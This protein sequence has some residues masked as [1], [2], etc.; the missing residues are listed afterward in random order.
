[1]FK[2]K[3]FLKEYFLTPFRKIINFFKRYILYSFFSFKY[4]IIKSKIKNKKKVLVAF[5]LFNTDT[6]KADTVFN[7][8]KKSE[9]FVPY[10]VICPLVGKGNSFMKNQYA[11]CLDFV[12]KNN[13]RYL[14]GFEI[15]KNDKLIKKKIPKFD[16][17]FFL[18]P[19][20]ITLKSFTV[21][22]NKNSLN[23]Y[24]PYSFNIDNLT[25]Y[26]YNN[27]NI[28]LMYKVFTLSEYHYN[29][30]KKYSDLKAKNCFV[31]GFPQL[32]SFF[33]KPKTNPWIYKNKSRKKIIWGPHWT[34][35][36]KQK[37]GLDWSC[38]LD[39]SDEIL[40]LAN[41]YENEV[42]FTLKPHPFLFQLL[43]KEDNWGEQKTNQYIAKWDETKNCQ[44][45]WGNY[46]DL[47]IHSDAL[48]HD[49]GSFTI[50]YLCTNK[51]VAYTI[52]SENY[53]NRFNDIGKK[54]IDLHHIIKDKF[55][56]EKF[57][58]EVIEEKDNM[59]KLRENFRNNVLLADG[60]SGERIVSHLNYIVK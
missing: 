10:I 33:S 52:N 51:P 7:E 38:F 36:G 9:K 24:I 5:Y 37:T 49:S 35:P 22:D 32:D 50:E 12:K 6:W 28:N 4:S 48:I 17:V 3:Y 27:F 54:A 45:L 1:M 20:N 60:K 15:L 53:T 59:N 18:N 57:I 44:I 23:C 41:K 39:Y 8:L 56:L 31:S 29:K 14:E 58:I 11:L 30:Y 26:E 2:I 19:N 21:V 55:D 16:I 46:T 13:Y 42:E 47:F 40:D 43:S 34:I 25:Q